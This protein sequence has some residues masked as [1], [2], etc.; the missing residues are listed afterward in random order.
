MEVFI[1]F[2][3]S[4]DDSSLSRNEQRLIAHSSEWA[5]FMPI[6]IVLYTV[7]NT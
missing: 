1:T 2:A 3:M 6:K 5:Y 7:A 4:T